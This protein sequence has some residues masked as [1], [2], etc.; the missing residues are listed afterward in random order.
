MADTLKNHE[1]AINLGLFKRYRFYNMFDPNG[2]RIFGRNVCRLSS[3]ALT[4][5]VLCL[6]VYGTLGFFTRMDD[7]LSNVDFLLV[8]VVNLQYYQ[9]L[10]RTGICL[11][12]AATIWDVFVVSKI[13]FFAS[14][15]CS[16]YLGL[17]HGY[18]DRITGITNLYSGF[19]LPV[20]FFWVM[21]PVAIGTLTGRAEH[22]RARNVMNL[23]FP[24]STPAYNRYF[25]VFYGAETVIAI[26]IMYVLLMV[27]VFFVSF[28]WIIIA[29]N[30]VLSR[31][32]ESVGSE[33]KP[34][35]GR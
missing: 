35:T 28:C 8:L 27:D 22:R 26:F 1:V 15:P 10:L 17:L 29:Q 5:V 34:Q 6:V 24:V 3:V 20:M 32:F 9:C 18:R 11:R 2:K 12:R 30:D 21:L 23:R 14:R 25:F 16:R 19:C 33:D 31:S 7:T 4:V 13:R